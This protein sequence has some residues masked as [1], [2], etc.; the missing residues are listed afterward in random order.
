MNAN[1]GKR[2]QVRHDEGDESFIF[3]VTGGQRCKVTRRDTDHQ[4]RPADGQEGGAATK[5]HKLTSGESLKN[6]QDSSV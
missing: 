5:I 3:G 4:L 6:I 2:G 1:E